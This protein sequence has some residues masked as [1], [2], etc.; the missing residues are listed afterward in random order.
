[1]RY[2]VDGEERES[3]PLVVH[4]G[5][6]TGV[7]DLIGWLQD[8]REWIQ[9]KLTVHGAIL[10][11]GFDVRDAPTF[12]S[13]ARAIAPDLSNDYLGTP[14]T[15]LATHVF[16]ASELPGPYPIAQ[17][18]EM[19]YLA[20]PPTRVFFC[21]LVPPAANTGETPLADF[22]KVW[23]DLDPA[24]RDRFVRGGIRIVRNFRGPRSARRNGR[25]RPT[26]PRGRMAPTRRATPSA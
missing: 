21:C 25:A 14:R 8:H 26:S 1:V 10:L 15:R 3:L 12:E 7:R 11:R 24:L 2:V 18:C 23:S 22:R 16:P 19:S 17:H 20:T 4:A 13:V 5:R 6:E 9:S